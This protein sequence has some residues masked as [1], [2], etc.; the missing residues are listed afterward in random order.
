MER[1]YRK[2]T[3]LK[4]IGQADSSFYSSRNFVHGETYTVGN[5]KGYGYYSFEEQPSYRDFSGGFVENPEL[6]KLDGIPK[7]KKF[8]EK[9]KVF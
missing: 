4:F 5:A 7:W 2:G 3:K 6:F 1:K 9:G 8:I